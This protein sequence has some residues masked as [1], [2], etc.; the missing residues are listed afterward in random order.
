MTWD[1]QEFGYVEY[2]KIL[3][4]NRAHKVLGVSTIS[5]G[6]IS[7]TL[8][9]P[10]VIFALALKTASSALILC[11]SHPSGNTKPS[12]A[13]INLTRKLVEGGRLLDINVLDHIILTD[14]EYF[15]FMEN[16]LI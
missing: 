5:Q 4:L 12:Q 13:D 7:G 3:L 6:G 8:A 9:D 11:H 1:P 15:S 14:E 10:K 2:F 16:G